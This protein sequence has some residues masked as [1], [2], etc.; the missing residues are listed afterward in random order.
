MFYEPIKKLA[1]ENANIQRGIVAAERMFE[2]LHIKPQISDHPNALE[3]KKLNI[4]LNLKM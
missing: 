3:I 1:E 2:V 4:L